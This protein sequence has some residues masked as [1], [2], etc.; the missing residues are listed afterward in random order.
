MNK[1]VFVGEDIDNNPI[2]VD[3]NKDIIHLL[4][5]LQVMACRIVY[6]YNYIIILACDFRCATC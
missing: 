1:I 4:Y 6:V 2:I 5:Q 3:A